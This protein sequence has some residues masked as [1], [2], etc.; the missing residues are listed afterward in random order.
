MIKYSMLVHKPTERILGILLSDEH[1]RKHK[2][3]YEGTKNKDIDFFLEGIKKEVD[4]Y[5]DFDIQKFIKYYINDFYF[6][7][8]KTF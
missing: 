5:I 4:F 2:F 7:E 8:I 1:S 6:T 3:I